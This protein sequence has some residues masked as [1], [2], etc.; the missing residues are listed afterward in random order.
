MVCESYLNT[1]VIKIINMYVMFPFPKE[2][3]MLGSVHK[4]RDYSFHFPCV[5]TK[6]TLIL[7]KRL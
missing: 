5:G 2:V 3:L 6:E 1:A 7:R 4:D